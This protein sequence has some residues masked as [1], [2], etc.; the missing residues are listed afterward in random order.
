MDK[1]FTAYSMWMAA[2]WSNSEQE[3]TL[4]AKYYEARAELPLAEQKHWPN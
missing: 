4:R 2:Y 3:G 1:V